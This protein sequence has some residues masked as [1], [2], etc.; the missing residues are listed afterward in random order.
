MNRSQRRKLA[1]EQDKEIAKYNTQSEW[2]DNLLPWQ[3]KV[4]E[5]ALREAKVN[6]EIDCIAT[7]DK[8][9]TGVLIEKTNMSWEETFKF[10]EAF[11]RYYA[12]HRFVISKFGK[13]KRLKMLNKLEKEIVTK[14]EKM[15][16]EGKG[17]GEIVKILLNDYK[18]SIGLTTP[19]AN[20][21]YKRTHEQYK[22]Y[23]KELEQEIKEIAINY[24]NE[25]KK[26]DDVKSLL[27]IEYENI[28]EKD[29]AD[30]VTA[31]KEE[32]MK[33]KYDDYTDV[34]YA[35]AEADK[36]TAEKKKIKKDDDKNKEAVEKV[37]EAIDKAG[38]AM[39]DAVEEFKK[40]LGE[41]KKMSS[42]KVTKEV[43]KVVYRELEGEFGK[44]IADENGVK[45]EDISFKDI[46][47]VEEYKKE[48]L[49]RF[50]REIAELEAV[51]AFRE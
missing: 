31:A 32:F 40:R 26:T 48:Q 27:K 23:V 28:S 13:E 18:E 11:G 47:A 16:V 12:E 38:K 41:E 43:T 44:Y 1:R 20:N 45:R 2:L 35:G 25:N 24:F 15:I 29:L 10:N 8:I 19:E 4:I 37:T 22:Q 36:K 33:P 46:A 51:F 21:V 49:E 6:A 9:L 7:V 17:R 50:E 42:L 39:G 14:V 5:T 30:I 34:P 3:K